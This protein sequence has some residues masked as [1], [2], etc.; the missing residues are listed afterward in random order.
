MEKK[1]CFLKI[2]RGEC[3]RKLVCQ[4]IY[5]PLVR[6]ATE[7][8]LGRGE[9]TPNQDLALDGGRGFQSLSDKN[10]FSVVLKA[11]FEDAGT[12]PGRVSTPSI[13]HE[14]AVMQT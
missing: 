8:L 3:E 5:Q 2:K 7:K 13:M 1:K 4:Q 10:V 14:K 9:R 12:S 11:K 6:G